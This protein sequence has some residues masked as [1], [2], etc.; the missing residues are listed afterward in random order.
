MKK[1]LRHFFARR[2]SSSPSSIGV[3]AEVDNALGCTRTFPQYAV[4]PYARELLEG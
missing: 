2:T 3:Y 4:V 1:P